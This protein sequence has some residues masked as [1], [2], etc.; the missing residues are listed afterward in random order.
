VNETVR[1]DII[2]VAKTMVGLEEK[3]I[4]LTFGLG[5]MEGMTAKNI[6]A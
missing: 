3:F 5:E 6:R 4:D 1:N 2:D